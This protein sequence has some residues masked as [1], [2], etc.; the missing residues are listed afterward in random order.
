M[1]VFVLH[2]YIATFVAAN[3]LSFVRSTT[4]ERIRCHPARCAACPLARR[5]PAVYLPPPLGH[6]F[7]AQTLPAPTPSHATPFINFARNPLAPPAPWPR[8]A[9]RANPRPRFRPSTPV[10]NEPTSSGG[11]AGQ[12]RTGPRG[13]DGRG[14]GDAA[15]APPRT[16]QSLQEWHEVGVGVAS[17]LGVWIFGCFFFGFSRRVV[18]CGVLCG[19][20]WWCYRRS[21][22][23]GASSSE[24][25]ERACVCVCVWFWLFLG[26]TGFWER[27]G[28]PGGSGGREKCDG[29]PMFLGWIRK[30]R[31]VRV[32]RRVVF[33]FL[34]RW[35]GCAHPRF[36]VLS[37]N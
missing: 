11:D 29:K 20:C 16:P 7:Y 14:G 37:K 22:F 4:P 9:R 28:R 35:L 26:G 3:L 10:I 1:F 25:Y 21:D 19:G 32:S 5:T 24:R 30:R 36:R 33:R 6:A 27:W 12:S 13:G 15:V 34:M 23:R 8:P 31:T 2:F 17:A 18:P